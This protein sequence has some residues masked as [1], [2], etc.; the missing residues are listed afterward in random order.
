[1]PSL[2]QPR[3]RV[4]RPTYEAYLQTA[5]WRSVKQRFWRG[6]KRECEVCG[7]TH[8]VQIHHRSYARKWREELADLVA[9]CESCHAET[10]KLVRSGLPLWD[11]H[12]LIEPRPT[13]VKRKMKFVRTVK[14]TDENRHLRPGLRGRSRR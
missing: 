1:V 8:K 6:R 7:G 12:T 14:T 10:H 13:K 9:L 5:H 2:P 4:N 11:A 3:R